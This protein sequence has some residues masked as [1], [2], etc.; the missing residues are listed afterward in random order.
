MSNIVEIILNDEELVLVFDIDGVLAKYEYGEHNHNICSDEEWDKNAE[1]YSKLI[2]ERAKPI[3]LMQYVIDNIKNK[4]NVYACSVASEGEAEAKKRFILSNYNIPEKN[5]ILVCNKMDKL[6]AMHEIKK[7]HPS[8]PNEKLVL[9][10]DTIESLTYVQDNSNYTTC[11]IS[12][13]LV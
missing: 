2:Y 8:L 9:I 12:S 1:Y 7:Q 11:H 10:D 13:F 3:K 4:E 5:I 6:Q